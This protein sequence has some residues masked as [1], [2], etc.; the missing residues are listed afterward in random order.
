MTLRPGDLLKDHRSGQARFRIKEL[1]CEGRS[2]FVA[3]GED[4][5][6]DNMRVV[7]KAIRYGESEDAAAQQERRAALR[8]ELEALTLPSPRLPEPIDWLEIDGGDGALEPVLVQEFISGRTLRQELAR[9]EGG[10]DPARALHL[11]RDLALALDELHQ[12]GWVFRELD[13]DHVII[14]YDDI[15]HLVGAGNMAR[16]EQRPLGVRAATDPRWSA[17]ESRAERSGKFLTPRGDLYAWGC[18]LSFLL[19]G[20]EP[21][22]HAEGPLTRAA[23]QRL[24]QLPEGYQR[25]LARA[26][27][28]LAK[29]RLKD[30]GA[31]LPFLRPDALPTAQ[32][33]GFAELSLPEPF[34]RH[35]PDNRASQSKLSAGPLI[36]VPKAPDAPA[37]PAEAVVKRPEQLPAKP[38]YQS[39]LPWASLFALT[40]AAGLSA[41]TWWALT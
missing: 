39:C 24:Q 1:L 20:H 15:I 7:L 36:S 19:T 12:Q 37:A 22:G 9:A 11:A 34:D 27:Q 14:G 35:L 32:T 25:L 18:L 40:T 8:L 30:M 13:P 2:H 17:P 4:T 33:P 26:L 5:H 10:L 23:Y 21:S 28:P 29:H 31:L 16:A 6:L 41:L 38:W 3:L